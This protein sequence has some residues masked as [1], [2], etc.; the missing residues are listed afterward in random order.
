MRQNV[1]ADMSGVPGPAGGSHLPTTGIGSC[2]WLV[3]AS[4][5]ALRRARVRFDAVSQLQLEPAVRQERATDVGES[6]EVDIGG[7]AT[8]CL[9]RA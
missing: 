2:I 7:F 9:A 6:E 1:D 5:I 4:R 3:S 8:P